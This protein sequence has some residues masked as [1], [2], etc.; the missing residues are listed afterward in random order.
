VIRPE[1]N[2]AVSILADADVSTVAISDLAKV[3]LD[4]FQAQLP[5]G[6]F[7]YDGD[8]DLNDFATLAICY[9][10]AA[11]TTAP[12]GCPSD[13]FSKPDL[14]ADGDVDLADFASFAVNFTG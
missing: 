9:S 4:D 10:G 7:D 6:D 12:P 1:V 13:Q 8:V 5:D 2:L 11:V 3:I 14:D